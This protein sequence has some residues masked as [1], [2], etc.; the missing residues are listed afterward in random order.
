M[1]CL[2]TILDKHDISICIMVH[3]KIV[4]RWVQIFRVASAGTIWFVLVLFF[5]AKTAIYA[6]AM[7]H[8]SAH[9][10]YKGLLPIILPFNRT[11]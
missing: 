8:L 1:K 3:T 9:A 10:S 5:S 7:F 2:K 6:Y 4:P 11:G